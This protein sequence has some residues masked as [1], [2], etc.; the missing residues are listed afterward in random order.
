M[1]LEAHWPGAGPARPGFP[2][3]SVKNNPPATQEARGNGNALQYSGVENPMG[4]GAWWDTVFE[5][6]KESDMLFSD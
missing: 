6:A 3:G 5:V 4:R 1:M 2:G